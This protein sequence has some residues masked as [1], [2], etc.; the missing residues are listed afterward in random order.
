[1]L[2]WSSLFVFGRHTPKNS[3]QAY[4]S[5]VLWSG[6]PGIKHNPAIHKASFQL[7]YHLFIPEILY[8]PSNSGIWWMWV[9]DLWI[10]NQIFAP[11]HY[12]QYEMAINFTQLSWPQFT[13]LNE[14]SVYFLKIFWNLVWNEKRFTQVVVCA[15]ICS[16]C[17]ARQCVIAN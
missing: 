9:Y 1:M 15:V 7:L 4:S 17:I 12:N 11:L 14:A 6:S 8:F 5:P 3:P 2:I 13:Y 10:I 16:L